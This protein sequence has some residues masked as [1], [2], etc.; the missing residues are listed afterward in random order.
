MARLASTGLPTDLIRI[1]GA[2]DAPHLTSLARAIERI[3]VDASRLATAESFHW[4]STDGLEVQGWLYRAQ[5]PAHGTIVCVHGGPTWHC[6]NELD[7]E[8]QCY[9]AAGFN[10]L[11]PNYRGSTGFSL[12]YQDAIRE[13]GWGSMEQNDIRCGIEALFDA[14]IALPGKVGM[15]GLSYGGYST[16]FAITR[17]P[18]SIVAA[19]APV[20]G[21]TDLVIDYRTTRPDL[22]PLSE[23]MMGGAPEDVPEKYRERSPIHFIDHIEGRLLIVQGRRDPNVTPEH[24]EVVRPLLDRAG[25]D[26]DILWF[27]DEGHG[28]EK[29]KNQTTLF[30]RLVSFFEDAFSETTQSPRPEQDDRRGAAQ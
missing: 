2:P 5:G 28:I 23:R 22:R 12:A 9:C 6:G 26:Y 15:T 20:C 21:M 19:A 11:V 8:P 30:Q 10:V 24:V 13:G 14:G 29:R 7:V 25:V 17:F 27:D 18:R 16:W 4:T 1:S 3:A